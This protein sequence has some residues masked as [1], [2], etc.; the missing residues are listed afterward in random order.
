MKCNVIAMLHGA[1]QV[2]RRIALV[3]FSSFYY[4]AAS[5]LSFSF[6]YSTTSSDDSFETRIHHHPARDNG[7]R[8]VLLPMALGRR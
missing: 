2:S 4:H 3:F 6:H 7:N 5:L 1:L 8:S